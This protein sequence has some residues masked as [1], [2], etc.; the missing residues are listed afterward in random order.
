VRAFDFVTRAY[1]SPAHHA[2]IVIHVKK[3]MR[4]VKVTVGVKIW[5]SH[6]CDAERLRQVLQ[7]AIAIRHANRA[8][9]ISFGKEQ[10]N[11]HPHILPQLGRIGSD[12]HVGRDLR[13]ARRKEPRTTPDFDQAQPAGADRTQAFHIA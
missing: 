8:N 7:L 11:G 12:L 5:K 3:R 4:S 2:A 10:L 1:T 9:V 6:L 13:R